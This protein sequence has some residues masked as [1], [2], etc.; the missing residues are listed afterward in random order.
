MFDVQQFRQQICIYI[1]G[2]IKNLLYALELNYFTLLEKKF[3]SLCQARQFESSEAQNTIMRQRGSKTVLARKIFNYTSQYKA[4]F[5]VRQDSHLL[6]FQTAGLSTPREMF[7]M[8]WLS[9][10]F[11][12]ALKITN[13]NSFWL[14]SCMPAFRKLLKALELRV[15]LERLKQPW[16]Y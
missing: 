11:V 3:Q 13:K 10:G 12:N 1:E 5:A 15:L 8:K 7:F 9:R 4:T 2:L 16:L 14:S 6:N